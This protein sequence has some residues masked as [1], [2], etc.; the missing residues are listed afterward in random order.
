MTIFMQFVGRAGLHHVLVFPFSVLT[1]N[2]NPKEMRRKKKETKHIMK[3]LIILPR[4]T[5]MNDYRFTNAVTVQ[6][7]VA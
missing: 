4:V 2:S 5:G 6:R 3:P 7:L 1:N